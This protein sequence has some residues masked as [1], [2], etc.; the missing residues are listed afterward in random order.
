MSNLYQTDF[1]A[2]TQEQAKLLKTQHLF[3]LD[4]DNL[5]EELESLGKKERQELRN[6]LAVL[7]GHLLKWQY[8]PQ[9]RSN[10]WLATMREQREQIQIL[11]VESPSLKPYLAEAF[12]LSYSSA[13][14]LAVKDTDLP[15]E[16]F[17]H[18]NPFTLLEVTNPEFLP[19]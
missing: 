7:I 14:N 16:T 2:W 11:L 17:P 10:N 12:T 15:Y 19:V 8:Q 5:V 3:E 18:T 4:I 9:N 1:H 13:V 6:R